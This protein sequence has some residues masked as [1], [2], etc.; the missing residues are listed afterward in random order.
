MKKIK[1][2]CPVCLAHLL[3]ESEEDSVTI[4]CDECLSP[5]VVERLSSEGGVFLQ[6]APEED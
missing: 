2:S 5:L 6:I 4:R 3:F 1:S